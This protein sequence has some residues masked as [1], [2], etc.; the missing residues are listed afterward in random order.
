MP[1][2]AYSGHTYAKNYGIPKSADPNLWEVCVMTFI[3]ISNRSAVKYKSPKFG[4]TSTSPTPA[5]THGDSLK[6]LAKLKQL[7][8]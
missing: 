6:R 4:S 5:P 2:L 8:A 7:D 1:D 3:H